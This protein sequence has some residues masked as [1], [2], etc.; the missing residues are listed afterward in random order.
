MLQSAI[1]L[2]ILLG[3][4]ASEWL[5]ILTG[6]LISAG[7]L[8]FFLELPYRIASTLFLAVLIYCVV[9]LLERVI[10][11]YGRRRFMATVLLSLL[12]T[13]LFRE[14][15]YY[16]SFIPQDMRP[17]GFIISGLIANDML[18]QGLVKTI[19]A[20]LLAAAVIRLVLTA[21]LFL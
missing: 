8:A 2:S 12:G 18:K 7:Y 21:G 9:R 1:G 15:S 19:L 20:T 13:A 11:I 6:G 5:G 3:F 14:L 16:L 10:F 17:V 4:V